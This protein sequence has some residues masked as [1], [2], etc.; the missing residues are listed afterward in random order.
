MGVSI[1]YT[2]ERNTPMSAEEQQVNVIV[3]KYNDHFELKESGETFCVYERDDSEPA[4]IFEGATK[5]PFSEDI[6]DM[7]AA[8]YYWLSCLTEIRRVIAGGEWHVHLDDLD[9]MWNEDEG[10]QMLMVD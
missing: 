2:C 1:Y 10:W 5:L 8:L 3:A 9:A 7:L 4:I 6:E